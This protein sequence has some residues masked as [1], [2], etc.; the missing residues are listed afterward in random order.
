MNSEQTAAGA[1]D[2]F[3]VLR[4]FARSSAAE[5]CDLC[6]L[7]LNRVHSHLLERKTRRILCG[8]EACSILFCDR[9]DGRYVRIPRG[10]RLLPDFA[11]TD[12]EW[13]EMMIPINLAFFFR[14]VDERIIA[15][16]PSP[17]GAIESQ[18]TLPALEARFA[19]FPLSGMRPEVEAL[20]VNRLPK[21]ESACIIAPIDECF[22]LVGIIRTRWRGLSGGTEV[23]DAVSDFLNELEQNV[24]A[25]EGRHA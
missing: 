18:L 23:W 15:M 2:S 24:T 11:F 13:E 4:R 12:L 9:E 19:T 21:R 25:R 10:A 20:L 3:A 5:R 1:T 14:S 22:R 8:C 17:A 16:Y 7:M 6:G